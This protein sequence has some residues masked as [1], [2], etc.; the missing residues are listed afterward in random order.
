M[1]GK[2]KGFLGGLIFVLLCVWT[3]Q[4]FSGVWEML[5]K[6]GAGLQSTFKFLIDIAR[7]FPSELG[8]TDWLW[9]RGIFAVIAIAAGVLSGYT[10]THREEKKLIG[11]I[12]AIVSLIST[13]LM[14]V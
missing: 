10:F 1:T 3:S 7:E 2:E 8:I 9:T 12:G 11:I 6:L 4:G 14:F 5:D 13:A